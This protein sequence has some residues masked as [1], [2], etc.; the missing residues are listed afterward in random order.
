MKYIK[1]FEELKEDLKTFCNTY[2][3]YLLDDDSFK[4]EI[5]NDSIYLIKDKVGERVD[6]TGYR[7]RHAVDKQIG[8]IKFNRRTN[9]FKLYRNITER[10]RTYDGYTYDNLV[11]KY[12][13][14]KEIEDYFIPFVLMLDNQYGIV[15]ITLLLKDNTL[16]ALKID[17]VEKDFDIEWIRDIY[18]T[19]KK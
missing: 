11:V 16:K 10:K 5:K 13:S 17:D 2:L 19:V 4:I 1:L 9:V 8:E 6:K 14:W 15:N 3:A 12:F 18:I 7:F